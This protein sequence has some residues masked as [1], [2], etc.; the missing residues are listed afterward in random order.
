M[1]RNYAAEY[2]RRIAR[3]LA[4]GLSRSQA[5]G[6]ARASETPVRPKP[7]SYL[8]DA[9]F[10]HAIHTMS[11]DELSAKEAARRIG[12]SSERFNRY[13]A[14]SSFA[15]QVHRRWKIRED[16]ARTVVL[17]SNGAQHVV[18]VPDKATASLVG[19]YST[20]LAKFY[21]TNDRS[22]LQP[23]VGIKIQDVNGRTYVLETNA[24]T[25]RRLWHDWS[26]DLGDCSWNND[27]G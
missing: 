15:E 22:V 19:R 11:S 7:L 18:T 10:Q 25:L 1:A 26:L 4:R 27:H 20:A 2:A 6:H 23:F 24:N 8:Q 16:V 13:L 9:A 14:E 17:Y 3:G 5:R 21:K 12:W